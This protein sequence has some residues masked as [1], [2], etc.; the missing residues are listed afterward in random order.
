METLTG[1]WLDGAMSETT[2]T[3]NR[4]TTRDTSR[5]STDDPAD[6]ATDAAYARTTAATGVW[7]V[8]TEDLAR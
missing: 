1:S 8:D 7:D 4:G 3:R 5:G 6:E 2:D